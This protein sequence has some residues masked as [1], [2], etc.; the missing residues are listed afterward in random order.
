VWL[1]VKEYNFSAKSLYD[2]LG[3]IQEG[4]LREAVFHNGKYDSIY[5]MS[6]LEKDYKIQTGI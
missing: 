3:F 5:V 1:D 4:L 6:I 2:Y